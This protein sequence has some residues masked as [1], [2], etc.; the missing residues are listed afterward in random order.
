MSELLKDRRLMATTIQHEL[1]HVV[2]LSGVKQRDFDQDRW[3]SEGIAEYIGWSPKPA[4]ASWR[5]GSV[6]D[7]FRS[8]M[9][10]KTIAAKPLGPQAGDRNGDTFYGLGHFAVDCLARQ[11]GEPKLF[12]FVRL[13]LRDDHTYDQAARHAFGKPFAAVDKACISWIRRQA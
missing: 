10:P 7:A 9:R 8:S 2:T 12:D 13:A 11:Y 5:R 3:L 4:T 1:G 6:H